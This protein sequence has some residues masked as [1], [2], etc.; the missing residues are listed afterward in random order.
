MVRFR[1][2]FATIRKAYL[3]LLLQISLIIMLVCCCCC[4]HYCF[5]YFRSI[6]GPS[7]FWDARGGSLGPVVPLAWVSPRYHRAFILSGP[8][9]PSSTSRLSTQTLDYS[10]SMS[11]T[12]SINHHVSPGLKRKRR[13]MTKRRRRR[14]SHGSSLTTRTDTNPTVKRPGPQWTTCTS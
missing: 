6:F 1:V 4:Y 10:F 14:R 2:S 3:S 13:K 12:F 7:Q 9:L 11:S 8:L 5:I